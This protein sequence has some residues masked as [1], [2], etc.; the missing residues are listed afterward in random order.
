MLIEVNAS[1]SESSR[2]FFNSLKGELDDQYTLAIE[3]ENS[4]DDI[5]WKYWLKRAS[6]HDCVHA[7]YYDHKLDESLPLNIIL[8]KDKSKEASKLHVSKLGKQRALFLD[9]DGI[10]NHDNGY[11]FKWDDFKIY[12]D[13][14][15]L[16]QLAKESGLKVIIVTNQSGIARNYYTIEDLTE[17]HL[18][19]NQWLDENNATVDGIYYCPFHPKG[20]VTQFKRT[21]MLRKPFPGMFLMANAEMGIDL[22]NSIMIGDKNSDRIDELEMRTLFIQGN[23]ELSDK[24]STFSNLKELTEYIKSQNIFN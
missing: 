5:D 1:L 21:S 3:A 22:E 13:I 8:Y 4:F 10:I 6:K 12:P 11:V 18:K 23:Y 19:M 15:V 24:D 2:N 20:E 9:R 7:H 16:I 14:V 17:L